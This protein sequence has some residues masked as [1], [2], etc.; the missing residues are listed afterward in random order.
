MGAY[1]AKLAAMILR[2]SIAQQGEARMIVATG[3][4][5]FEVLE[6]LIKEPGI[7]WT[8]IDAFHLDEY[9]GIGKDHPASFCGYLKERFVERVPLRSYH[10]L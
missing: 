9:V 5:Q 3:S 1:S 10:Y 2:S 8:K 4:S 6:S 7:D